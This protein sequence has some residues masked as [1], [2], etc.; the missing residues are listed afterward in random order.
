[1]Q[2]MKYG[3]RPLLNLVL[4]ATGA[5]KSMLINSLL[6]E[7]LPSVHV[8]L[9]GQVEQHKN[10]CEEEACGH[11]TV[12]E[13]GSSDSDSSCVDCIGATTYG[14]DEGGDELRRSGDVHMFIARL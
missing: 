6:K 1:M 12:E 4:V 3:S 7:I 5:G 11:L 13:E 10:M 8:P 9:R 2:M 14:V